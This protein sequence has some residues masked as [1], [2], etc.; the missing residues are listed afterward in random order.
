MHGDIGTGNKK[1]AA[2]TGLKG[3]NVKPYSA[4]K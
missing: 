3:Q 2:G 4:E 1:M